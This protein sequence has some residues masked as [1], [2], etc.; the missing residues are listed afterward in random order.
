M[1]ISSKLCR[2]AVLRMSR[3][4]ALSLGHRWVKGLPGRKWFLLVCKLREFELINFQ[5]WDVDSPF[6]TA[7]PVLFKHSFVECYEVSHPA[8]NDLLKTGTQHD[9]I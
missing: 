1:S 3:D 4:N 7:I 5:L 6:V 2:L 9:R 8:F